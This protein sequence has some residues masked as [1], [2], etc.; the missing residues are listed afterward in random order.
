MILPIIFTG[1]ILKFQQSQ[2]THLN[3]TILVTVDHACNLHVNQHHKEIFTSA[4]AT[5]CC[6][7][8][9]GHQIKETTMKR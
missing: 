1:Q 6:N 7:T 9:S 3:Y 5:I 4:P 2:I 8:S